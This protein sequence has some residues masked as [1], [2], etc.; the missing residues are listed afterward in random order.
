MSSVENR[1]ERVVDGHRVVRWLAFGAGHY[2]CDCAYFNSAPA[3]G[4]P[5][6]WC[7]HLDYAFIDQA[8]WSDAT[9]IEVEKMDKVLQ[10]R[11]RGA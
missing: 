6:H 9:W 5:R 10:F 7:W 1:I 11:R 2:R 8:L 4:G 3:D